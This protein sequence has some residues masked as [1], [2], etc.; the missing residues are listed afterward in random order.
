MTVSR[1]RQGGVWER[2]RPV[3][4]SD[5]IV[6]QV[7][8]AVFE[9]RLQPG[10]ALGSENQLAANFGVSRV[11]VR[12]AIRSLEATGVVEIRTGVKGGVRVASGDPYRFADGLAIQLKLVG[13]NPA[14]ALAA[15]LGLEWV[16][17]E[18]AAAN[19][20]PDDLRAL[21]RLLDESAGLVETDA[22]FAETGGDFHTAIAE[23][24]HNWAII[25]SLRAIRELLNQMH[26]PVR[27]ASLHRRAQRYHTQL[28]QAIE[29]RDGAKAGQLM[30][31]HIS[32]IRNKATA[33][34]AHSSC[35]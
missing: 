21:K 33:S 18:L 15:Q 6:R 10:D 28:Y 27:D 8:Q 16:A 24:S 7:R 2:I 34:V 4:A 30:R 20:T 35:A 22:A 29:A 25:T 1:E 23:A 17:A 12:D 19:A 13:L 5:E 32:L 11:T 9:G 3:R 26:R 14:D 31:H